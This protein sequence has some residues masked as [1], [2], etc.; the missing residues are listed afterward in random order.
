MNH[1]HVVRGVSVLNLLNES[2]IPV[3]EES[4]NMKTIDGHIPHPCTHHDTELSPNLMSSLG[5]VIP[6]KITYQPQASALTKRVGVGGK[7]P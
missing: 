3:K 7:K 1:D 4:S 2:S 5:K 6:P